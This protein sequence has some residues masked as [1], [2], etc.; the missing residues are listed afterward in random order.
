MLLLA[1]HPPLY[2]HFISSSAPSACFY[3]STTKR[4]ARASGCRGRGE[5]VRMA[6]CLF[7]LIQD[8]DSDSKSLKESDWPK[9]F[10]FFYNRQTLP[11]III[12]IFLM[13]ITVTRWEGGKHVSLAN[14]TSS[15]TLTVIRSLKIHRF[16]FQ[17]YSFCARGELFT[18]N[19][20]LQ[21]SK[22]AEVCDLYHPLIPQIVTKLQIVPTCH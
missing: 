7:L 14:N 4:L 6:H 15:H 3:H 21:P 1:S 10:N 12:I 18:F 19:R 5:G 22:G 20:T 2:I 9:E 17:S 8:S 11:M 16:D 13:I